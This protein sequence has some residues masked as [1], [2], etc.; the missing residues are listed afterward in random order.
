[1]GFFEVMSEE[2][3]AEREGRKTKET[4]KITNDKR[5]HEKFGICRGSQVMPIKPFLEDT[6]LHGGV[7]EETDGDLCS[8]R[9]IDV[10]G[11]VTEKSS[12]TTF[13]EKYNVENLR[14]ME[15]IENPEDTSD[16]TNES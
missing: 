11:K 9:F 16:S 12:A 8:V 14:R 15:D 10:T 5:L 1:M 13:I 4:E 3:V 6:N 2:E 7:V